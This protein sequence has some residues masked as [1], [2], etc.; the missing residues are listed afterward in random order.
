[1]TLVAIYRDGRRWEL[2]RSEMSEPTFRS[3]LC[4]LWLMQHTVVMDAEGWPVNAWDEQSR[5]SREDLAKVA[6]LFGKTAAHA[7]EQK[8]LWGPS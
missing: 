4:S 3:G 5:P 6:S 1:M 7:V 2:V 8:L